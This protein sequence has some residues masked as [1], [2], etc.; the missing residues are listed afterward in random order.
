MQYWT[1]LLCMIVV[2]IVYAVPAW[3]QGYPYESVDRSGTTPLGDRKGGP[4][5]AKHF[6]AT[7]TYSQ[8]YRHANL[9]SITAGQNPVDRILQ[10]RDEPTD[11]FC[12]DTTIREAIL[13]VRLRMGPKDYEL[14]GNN[15]TASVT[16]TVTGYNGVTAVPGAVYTTT[17]M[18]EDTIPERLYQAT[19][20]NLYS[21]IETFKIDITA[22]TPAYSMGSLMAS[23]FRNEVRLEVSYTEEFLIDAHR[24]SGATH[25]PILKVTAQSNE[26][27]ASRV[28]F[29]WALMDDCLNDG[30]PNYQF[31]ILRLFNRDATLTT[32]EKVIRDTIDWSR[33]LSIETGN[34]NLSLDLTLAEGTGYYI[35]RV[36][37]IGNRYPG[38]IANDRNWG[39]WS[40]TLAQGEPIYLSGTSKA[41]ISNDTVKWSIFFYNQFDD[42]KN[43]VYSRT[44][45]EGSEGTRSSEKI[46][47]ANSLLQNRQIQ[48]KRQT[49]DSLLASQT[50]LDLSGRPS[51]TSL[52]V[53][54]QGVG[55]GIVRGFGY[56]P[57][58]L[59]YGTSLYT[60]ARFD[61]DANFENPGLDSGVVHLY[62]SNNNQN[63]RVPNADRYGFSR[64]LYYPDGTGRVSKQSGAGL[65]HRLVDSAGI[66]DRVTRYRYSDPTDAELIAMFG[67]EAPAASTV[68]KITTIDPNKVASVKYVSK[69]GQTIATC[70]VRAAN[71]LMDSLTGESRYDTTVFKTA[72][73]NPLSGLSGTTIALNSPQLVKIHYTVTPKV[74]EA[75]CGTV[76]ASCDYLLEFIVTDLEHPW[77]SVYYAS[78][79]IPA[80]ACVRDTL[81]FTK[82]VGVLDPGTYR[83]QRRLRSYT[84]KA[85]TVSE[86]NPDGVRYIDSM[87]NL[88]R[89]AVDASMPV[90]IDSVYRYLDSADLAGLYAYLKGAGGEGITPVIVE[91]D[92]TAYEIVTACCTLSVPVRSCQKVPCTPIPSFEDMLYD[93][94]G[95]NS[96]YNQ[97]TGNHFGS[98]P[99]GYFYRNGRPLYPSTDEYPDGAGAFDAMIEHMITE[100]GYDCHALKDCWMG[101]VRNFRNNITDA[102]YDASIAT[103]ARLGR[104]GEEINTDYDLLEAFLNC[105]GKKYTGVSDCP[106][107]DCTEGS[108]YGK[109]YLE[110]AYEYFRYPVTE[111]RCV[112]C[113]E[114]YGGN[115][116]DPLDPPS[117]PA[118]EIDEPNETK[119]WENFYACVM[120]CERRSD[121]FDEEVR[122][123]DCMRQTGLQVD[124]TCI[125]AMR[126]ELRDTCYSRC[127]SRRAAF[128]DAVE[129]LYRDAG[130]PIEGDTEMPNGDTIPLG[131]EFIPKWTVECQ[132][133]AM[134]DTCRD[135]CNLS[136][137]IDRDTITILGVDIVKDSIRSV[138]T[139]AEIA[140][141]KRS[142]MY[143]GVVALPDSVGGCVDTAMRS[144]NPYRPGHAYAHGVVA[145]LNDALLL[146]R[147]EGGD[148]ASAAESC[149]TL[150]QMFADLV[151]SPSICTS[152]IC[153]LEAGTRK[154][155]AR[156]ASGESD[157][158]CCPGLTIPDLF[159][160][161]DP[162]VHAEFFLA[163][164]CTLAYRRWCLRA[165]QLY[166]TVD[167]LCSNICIDT[168]A[169][170][171]C[172]KWVPFQAPDSV[173]VV[174]RAY[175]C[176]EEISRSIRQDLDRQRAECRDRQEQLFRNQY[177]DSCADP[178]SW[179]E[180]MRVEY[181]ENLYHFTLF[182]YDR[183]GNLIRT[184][185]PQGVD[186]QS[187]TRAR[188]PLHQLA[189]RYEYN[190][191]KQLISQRTPDGNGTYFMYD[192]KGQLR[193]SVNA[194]QAVPMPGLFSYTIYDKLGRAVQAGE[195]LMPSPAGLL[196]Q[197]VNDQTYPRFG[198]R[199]VTST[200][201]TTAA[202]FPGYAN[203]SGRTQRY[204][205]NRV[206][207]TQTESGVITL[208]S[209]DPHG[210]VEW[211][212]SH[213]PGLGWNYVGYEYDL[214]SGNVL[215]VKYDEGMHDEFLQRYSYDED[216]RLTSVESS[217]HGGIWDRDA[218]YDYFAHGPLAR[219][220]LGE[221]RLQGLDYTYT[222]QGW[223][224]A[225]NH[226]VQ[227]SIFDP[228]NDGVITVSQ[229][230][231]RDAFGMVLGYFTGD[232]HRR[233]GP[234]AATFQN[235]SVY[236]SGPNY[237]LHA[238]NLNVTGLF[239]GNIT[240]WT[241]SHNAVATVPF[242]PPTGGTF[243]YG[244]VTGHVYRYDVLNRLLGSDFRRYT[245][246]WQLSGTSD[247]DED[248]TYDA[249]GNIQTLTRRAITRG[250][251][252]IMDAF[253]Y[254]HAYEKAGIG[255]DSSNRLLRVA[256]AGSGSAQ[257]DSDI[258]HQASGTDNYKYDPSG[259][260]IYD[261][262]EGTQIKWNGFGKVEEVRK[263][264]TGLGL[265]QTTRFVYN[266]AGNRVR[267][268]VYNH[269]ALGHAD[270]V[271]R[272]TYY[273]RDANEQVLTVYEQTGHFVG[274]L[275]T[276]C[277]TTPGGAGDG[278]GDGVVTGTGCERCPFANDPWQEDYDKDGVPD[279]CDANPF[280]APAAP[281]T[282]MMSPRVEPWVGLQT[283]LSEQYVYG[284]G[285]HGR[286]AVSRPD[287]VRDTTA[288]MNTVSRRRIGI[289]EYELK[290]HL[291]NVRV[292]ISDIKQNSSGISSPAF[293][294]KMKSV[295]NYYAY[296][297]LEPGRSWQSGEYRYGYN[298]KES[299]NEWKGS[300][301]SSNGG[302]NS[303]D[304]GARVYDARLG[305]WLSLDPHQKRYP[306]ISPYS[307]V[308][309][310]PVRMVD[311]GGLDTFCVSTNGWLNLCRETVG[312]ISSISVY[313][314][315]ASSSVH[316]VFFGISTPGN[317]WMGG[318][319]Y[320]IEWEQNLGYEPNAVN[321]DGIHLQIGTF[322]DKGYEI[323]EG[324]RIRGS[325]R[326][327][328]VFYNSSY[329]CS[330]FI[331]DGV[332]DTEKS[333]ESKTN[334]GSSSDITTQ[335][336]D[337]FL[338]LVFTI[339]HEPESHVVMRTTDADAD[340]LFWGL[341]NANP[342]ENLA[343]YLSQ[344]L[345]LYKSKPDSP[346]AIRPS[347]AAETLLKSLIEYSKTN[348]E[349]LKKSIFEILTKPNQGN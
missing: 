228:G 294:V 76:C 103:Y 171:I 72:E 43:W 248:F 201:Y 273:V 57:Q 199:Y 104:D 339:V 29:A 68:Q 69:E 109:G 308:I 330:G 243:Q 319:Y 138:G 48:A 209:Y 64:V 1:I 66:T 90:A 226:P 51:L 195:A 317:G 91:G 52:A 45:T 264:V 210:N 252:N 291:G 31:Q 305:R 278:D 208:Y 22:Y 249:N 236:N 102:P 96:D 15:F 219:V 310:S 32:D 7:K 289:K 142:M 157:S 298:G 110:Y 116:I 30:I 244:G 260:L 211:M 346:D 115:P 314:I 47:Y 343:T 286:V 71:S 190:S 251:S 18:I 124:T 6:G 44:F 153:E 337:R 234:N 147:E 325:R 39:V 253:T 205:R 247:Y 349:D 3:G 170:S 97:E 250:A 216:N 192:D 324:R 277:W 130:E 335:M 28:A 53:P 347:S 75:E 270:S 160:Q 93:M 26:V 46:A 140:A 156:T 136:I 35:W 341:P 304:Y 328:I 89:E 336:I 55:S 34:R 326:S 200:T 164:T 98:T 306:D 318:T 24:N 274:P 122:A 83:I 287:T 10:V 197:R 316:D 239:N 78:E 113:E 268:L 284:S 139:A 303:L 212:A 280:K 176:E 56:K 65:F 49:S 217:R 329:F 143:R 173:G 152:W 149:D 254:D 145:R 177:A 178:A 11:Y 86:E 88:V 87:A 334:I 79:V 271:A 292:V 265:T 172:F 235:S 213:I 137:V 290:D 58:L 9:D 258:D 134:I 182:Y 333:S 313:N 279:A 63:L 123:D 106:Y 128:Q 107:G 237:F 165:G 154:S 126:D 344:G 114:Q 293:S 327:S 105:A 307:Y 321:V 320:D 188:H 77:E 99:R 38:G 25:D 155:G 229:R 295:S 285:M 196:P 119:Q 183:A 159:T 207:A 194:R 342:Y 221:D 41:S 129:K 220:E 67:D 338:W 266:G 215:K 17:L 150:R 120:A 296:G 345:E 131:T 166:V 60:A 242:P 322:L 100:G 70:L 144:L 117:W 227:D 256:D 179:E 262:Q 111:E 276:N 5:V 158:G 232:F 323:F 238:Q 163:D 40:R 299:D 332:I 288:Y 168:C 161:S 127:E 14:G 4:T 20:T 300:A 302:G 275:T 214:I 312:K 82:S 13:N 259:N 132:V 23:E 118:D 8:T 193:F 133:Q 311:I 146:Y 245:T 246:S 112:M 36:R 340:H 80:G 187:R 261:A 21:D 94:W 54:I 255:P 269:N 81:S 42:D 231:A 167:T 174:I 263:V 37:P 184:I 218:G 257:F 125:A 50:V 151:G 61:A 225:I 309:N 175:T 181:G 59:K 222:L 198:Q 73:P 281:D 186:L 240:T 241:L 27:T 315:L 135:G 297:M 141:Y 92:T 19:F 74:V 206:S 148:T 108:G 282:A 95:V 33:A 180:E 283:I 230:Y 162:I 121:R 203:T 101:L 191:V 169:T 204:L 301:N 2:A 16:L 84:T 185:P 12:A 272:I 189:T 348:E 267:K 233:R 223:L 224:K 331:A 85:G 202:T 62:Y